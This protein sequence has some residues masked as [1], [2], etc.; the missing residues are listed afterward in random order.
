MGRGPSPEGNRR[1]VGGEYV[2]DFAS[3]T[4][5]EL[6]TAVR[7]R[8]QRV[9]LALADI[10]ARMHLRATLTNQNRAGSDRGA[11]KHLDAKTLCIGVPTVLC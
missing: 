9:V 5:A 10:Q 2:D 8:K 7:Q 3:A 6:H 1:L 11:V 4:L